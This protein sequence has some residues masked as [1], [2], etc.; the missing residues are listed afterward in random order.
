MIKRFLKWSLVLAGLCGAMGACSTESAIQ[1]ALGARATAPVFLG[2]K[3][4][5]PA[6]IDF[7]FSLPVEVSSLFFDPTLEVKSIIGGATVQIHLNRPALEGERITANILVED[8]G[9]NTLDVLIPFRARNDRLPSFTITELRTEYSK[10]KVEFVEIKTKN[11]GN[12]GALRLF[13][14]SVSMDTP[15]WEFPPVEVGGNEYIV[16][17]LRSIEEGTVN[18]T[19][20]NLAASGGT[21]ASPTARDFW[22]PGAAKLLH[23]TGAVYFMDQDDRIVDGILLCE[24]DTSWSKKEFMR[25]AAELLKSQGA[26]TAAA[27]DIPGPQDAVASKGT[28]VTRSISRREALPDSNGKADWYITANSKA[29]PGKP[30]NPEVYVPK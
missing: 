27:G 15:I 22:V 25:S 7:Q 26:W 18:E 4:V 12:L 29:S 1:K 5:S 6:E 9:G 28:T 8:E 30:N 14:A 19:G 13:S 20:T 23:K 24:D 21:E 2:Y 16:I 11:P 10:P 3:A 17:H